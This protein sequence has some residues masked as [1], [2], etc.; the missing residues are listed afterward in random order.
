MDC[1]YL[2]VG[3]SRCS[4]HL[5]IGH[6]EYAFERCTDS[7]MD[8]PVYRTLMGLVVRPEVLGPDGGK[9]RVA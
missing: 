5:S 4:E 6:L 3:D 8:C 1:P 9:V 7:Y 2:D